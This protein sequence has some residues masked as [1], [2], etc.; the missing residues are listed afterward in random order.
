[1]SLLDARP[2]PSRILG[3]LHTALILG[4]E[5]NPNLRE[6]LKAVVAPPAIF[7]EDN[8]NETFRECVRLGVF[9]E[10][11]TRGEFVINEGFVKLLPANSRTAASD[12][13]VQNTLVPALREQVLN[14]LRQEDQ[15]PSFTTLLAWTLMQRGSDLPLTKD[16]V[17]GLVNRQHGDR[18]GISFNLT[19]YDPFLDWARFLGF[20]WLH[21]LKRGTDSVTAFQPDPY[22]V[23]EQG[24]PRWFDGAE[25]SRL[26]LREF[27]GR[28]E[29]DFPWLEDG[30]MAR[31][32]RSTLG[33]GPL[34]DPGE[35]TAP[36]ALALRRL[37]KK[38]HIR[39]LRLSDAG[40]ENV[41]SFDW[42]G[43]REAESDIELLRGKN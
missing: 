33:A 42:G 8:F 38:G 16:R 32:V 21:S 9:E 19:P 29:R 35:V 30:L 39:L 6:D 12:E 41:Y 26:S 7:K 5:G 3:L 28:V 17:E 25:Q 10:T 24:L 2:I 36:V 4:S 34:R 43:K 27:F 31:K 23:L 37:E 40:V 20:G 22:F 1:M 13:F 11:E 18:L 14:R 15:D